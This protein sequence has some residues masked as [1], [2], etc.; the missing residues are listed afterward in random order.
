M[1]APKPSVLQFGVRS[2]EFGV[3]DFPQRNHSELSNSELRTSSMAGQ[4]RTPGVEP[5]GVPVGAGI[6]GGAVELLDGDGTHL[7]VEPV[8]V[9]VVV[10]REVVPA[11][12]VSQNDA[13]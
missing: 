3:S 11:L 13:V 4:L 8:Q 10:L 7:G 1:G 2:S 6:M 5:G 9:V 12:P